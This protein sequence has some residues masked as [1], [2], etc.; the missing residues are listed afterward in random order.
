MTKQLSSFQPKGVQEGLISYWNFD[1][2]SGN[3]IDVISGNNL[4]NNGNISYVAGKINNCAVG[5]TNGRLS[6]TTP[7]LSGGKASS[8]VSLWFNTVGLNGGS[9]DLIAEVRWTDYYFRILLHDFLSP[10]NTLWFDGTG[11]GYNA[12]Y[13]PTIGSWY[14]VVLTTDGTNVRIYVN[15]TLASTQAIGSGA[16]TPNISL[17]SDGGTSFFNGKIDEMCIWNRTLN[18]TEIS[19]IY[20]AG[21][22]IQ[23][24][25]RA[26]NSTKLYMPLNGSSIDISGN[27]NHGTDTN[28]S[29]VGGKFGQGARFNGSSSQI[30]FTNVPQTGVGAFTASLWVK[31]STLTTNMEILAW[32]S[33]S[34]HAGFDIY[35]NSS[36]VMTANFYGGVGIASAITKVSTQNWQYVTVTYD[37][38]N[39]RIYINGILEGISSSYTSA[40]VVTTNKF[41]GKDLGGGNWWDGFADE[42]ILENRA[43][44]AQEISAYYRKSMITYKKKTL[45]NMLK[46]F[47]ISLE[48]GTFAITGYNASLTA[49]Q[50]LIA[51]T[52]AYIVTGYNS[53]MSWAYTMV[54]QTGAYVLTGYDA[55]I[56]EI[57][58]IAGLTGSFILS[59][60]DAILRVKGWMKT[61]KDNGDGWTKTP[62]D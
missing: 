41:I 18:A 61:P 31:G 10:S 55:T 33:A 5:T 60:K 38:T 4:T 51:Q 53:I 2:T 24:T 13:V 22:G 34:T 49:I 32:G 44:T 28:I 29:Y 19:A 21:N 15:G 16:N 27:G 50:V 47:I 62:K 54:A 9:V 45:F 14:H 36:N 25:P 43:W 8:S 7:S 3:A 1:H 23:P 6:N 42:I 35:M 39:T 30:L 58:R 37:G 40:S 26:F 12:G 59:G 52:G 56:R 57:I 17:F 20:N 46:D 48:T 11:W